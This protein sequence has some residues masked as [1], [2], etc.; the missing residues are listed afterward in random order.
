MPSTIAKVKLQQLV[1]GG[2]D[3]GR[4]VRVDRF[5]AWDYKRAAF[6]EAYLQCSNAIQS[7]ENKLRTVSHTPHA[8]IDNVLKDSM[9]WKRKYEQVSSKQKVEED[10]A[11][12]EI[13]ILKFRSSAAEARLVAA[14]EQA[15]FAQEE[16]EE[17]KQK[18]HIAEEE[19]KDKVAKIEQ[20]E[21]HLTTLNL[22]LKVAESKIK[23]YDMEISTLKREIKLGE[24]LESAST[25]AQSF[26]REAR[27]LEQEKNLLEQKY[28]S[29][30]DRFGEVQE[31]CKIAERESKRAT[32]AF[33]PFQV[34]LKKNFQL[35]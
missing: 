18:Y 23:N 20:T 30:F 33:D 27:I 19:M 3:C 10:Q 26:E 11:S 1:G 24:R 14:R 4:V 35:R 16:A 28:Q 15:Q 22:E 6:R 21:Q 9:E 8:K 2:V 5:A 13:A 17:W 34:F 25:T 7:M 31:R 29:K 32:G 12:I